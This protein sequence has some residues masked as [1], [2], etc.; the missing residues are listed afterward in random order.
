MKTQLTLAICALLVAGA[1]YATENQTRSGKALERIS[2]HIGAHTDER[3]VANSLYHQVRT[4]VLITHKHLKPAE[5]NK[6]VRDYI[7]KKYAPVLLMRYSLVYNK[8]KT[9]NRHFSDCA[10]LEPFAYSKDIEAAMCTV[11]DYGNTHVRY[12]VNEHRKGWEK[13]AEFV[14]QSNH[15]SLK[16]VAI[17]LNLDKGQKI[18]VAGL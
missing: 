8:M 12:L 7:A 14:F 6:R 17:R 13:T 2:A 11:H 15:D 10:K 4:H 9:A 18:R 1:S 16:L 5:I 3:A